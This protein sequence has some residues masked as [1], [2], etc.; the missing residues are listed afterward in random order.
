LA[1]IVDI[2]II[3]GAMDYKDLGLWCNQIIVE[4]ASDLYSE[5]LASVHVVGG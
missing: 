5:T 4:R 2:W 1:I 3:M